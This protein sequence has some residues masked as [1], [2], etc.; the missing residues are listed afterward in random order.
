MLPVITDKEVTVGSIIAFKHL[1]MSKATN[2]QPQVSD[3][4]VARVDKI[5]ENGT[6]DMILARRDREVSEQT[7]V[8]ERRRTEIL[9]LRDG[10]R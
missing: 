3:Y 7:E 8:E 1:F 9:R 2:W 10:G 4:K 6:L 5:H